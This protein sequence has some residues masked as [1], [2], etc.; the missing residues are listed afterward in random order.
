M[1]LT[2]NK[3]KIAKI[4]N[5]FL[6]ESPMTKVPLNMSLYKNLGVVYVIENTSN[7]LKYIG[8]SID[9]NNRANSYINAY[10][11]ENPDGR[12]HQPVVKAMKEIGI[13]NFIM[14][15]IDVCYGRTQL[16][17]KEEFY[18]SY[19]KTTD[20]TIG[21]NVATKT[22]GAD[23]I[24]SAKDNVGHKHS[25]KTKAN[26]AKFIAAVNDTEKIMYVSEGLKLFADLTE[27]TKDLVKN[28][29]RAGLRHRGYYIIY[30]NQTDRSTIYEKI[31]EKHLDVVN[32]IY[33]T[34]TKRGR[35]RANYDSYLN[36]ADLVNQL[37]EDGSAESFIEAGYT[38]KY[39]H[40]DL[41][42]NKPYLIDTIDVFFDTIDLSSFVA[43]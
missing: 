16:R 36:A 14:Y 37:L 21:Y 9:F 24:F 3:A 40:Y 15:P 34:K 6:V 25:E 5:S 10:L 20:P 22:S 31:Y 11:N 38:C 30:L 35:W 41:S 26:K 8:S 29:A 4:K 2:Y 23:K 12:T 13:E 27:S 1:D 28:E 17:L 42:G 32:N 19:Y 18:I 43:F 39:L 7:G 33:H